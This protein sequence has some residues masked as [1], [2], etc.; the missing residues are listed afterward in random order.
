MSTLVGPR[1][2]VHDLLGPRT[3]PITKPEFTIGRRSSNDLHLTGADISRDHA[4][5]TQ[6][7]GQY[8]VRDKGSRYGTFINGAR[9]TERT[10]SHGDRIVLGRDGG[11]ELVFLV[12]DAPAD[13]A[14]SSIGGDL[15]QMSMLLET[16]RKMGGGRVLDEVL[17]MALDSAIEVTGA[18]RGFIMLPNEA[19]ALEMKIARGMGR[20]SL[21]VGGFATS[22]KIPEEVYAS[23]RERLVTDLRE[24]DLLQAHQGTIAMGI[25]HVLCTP[26]RLVRYLDH[27]DAQA[28]PTSIGVLYL[29][30]REKGKLLS[31]ATRDALE[32]LARE[33]AAAIENARLYRET[34]EKARIDQ[35]LRTAAQIQQA[36]LPPPRKSAGFFSAVASSIPC[37]AIGG[38]FYDYLDL[39]DGKFGFALGDVAGK[40]P[41]AALLTAVL[42]GIFSAQAFTDDDASAMTARINRILLSRHIE[43]R[44]ATA[45]FGILT[46]SGELT[47]TNAGH[48]AP[49]LFGRAGVRRLE[50]GG[51]V[52]GLFPQAAYAQETVH[53]DHGDLLVVFSDGVS[54]ALAATGEEFGDARIHDALAGFLAEAPEQLVER[55]LGAVRDFTLGAVQN[56]DITAL[57]VKYG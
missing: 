35:E 29:D 14:G 22:R 32:T 8:L 38:D 5:I 9:I 46:P 25:R 51:M 49:F 17:M 27:A 34:L 41:P 54:E 7:N 21:P 20:L 28:A 50:T 47:Y 33:A 45:F 57:I 15:R 10:L 1:L 37:R 31:Q 11:A 56:D 44:F 53:L 36:L 2:D 42:Q 26:L 39:P 23:G 55:L 19:G 13:D 40:G 4:E 52:L 30:S 16:L 43:S 48:N 24:G 6:V 18:E 3:V 12:N